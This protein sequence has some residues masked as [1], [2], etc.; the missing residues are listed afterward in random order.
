MPQHQSAH[1]TV[2]A[3]LCHGND[4][5]GRSPEHKG[6]RGPDEVVQAEVRHRD[7]L[8]GPG[9]PLLVD[10]RQDNPSGTVDSIMHLMERV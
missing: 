10:V 9:V 5:L 4:V 6:E 8:T 7:F 2:G 3:D 1:R